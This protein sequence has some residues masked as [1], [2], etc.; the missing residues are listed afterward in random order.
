M[1]ALFILPLRKAFFEKDKGL[2]KSGL[3]VIGFAVISTIGVS[4]VSYESYIYTRIPLEI[5]WKDYPES[6]LYIAKKFAHKKIV[7]IASIILMAFISFLS[8]AG[9]IAALNV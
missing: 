2:L 6:I 7:T 4:W 1:I 8:I 9:Y 3:I 5:Q